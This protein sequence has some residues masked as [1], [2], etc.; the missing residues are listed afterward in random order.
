[1]HDA[2]RVY[3]LPRWRLT[4]WLADPGPRVPAHLHVALVSNLFGTLPVFARG[5]LNTM[6]VAPAGS[7]PQPSVCMA[8]AA[9]RSE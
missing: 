1:M 7:A 2:I 3:S 6:L 9:H 8:R 5:V 4:Q